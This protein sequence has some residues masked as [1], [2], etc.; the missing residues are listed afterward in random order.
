MSPATFQ[1][2]ETKKAF[3]EKRNKQVMEKYY[4][5]PEYRQKLLNDRIALDK[6]HKELGIGA[7]SPERIA[8]RNEMRKIKYAEKKAKKLAEKIVV[9]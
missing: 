2:Q 3:Y 5:D 4:S 9:V 1:S 6:K 8:R 7:Y